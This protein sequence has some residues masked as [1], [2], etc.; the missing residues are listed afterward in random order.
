MAAAFSSTSTSSFPSCSFS[1]PS[2]PSLSFP[3][4]F[5]AFP[6]DIVLPSSCNF[7]CNCNKLRRGSLVQVGAKKKK[8]GRSKKGRP[9]DNPNDAIF[10]PEA[11]LL[12]K[13]VVREDGKVL[14]EFA[15]A[16]EEK[17]YQALSLQLESSLNL[18]RMRHYE[19]VFL[20]HGKHDAET[21]EIVTK[22]EDFIREKKGRIYRL[23]DWGLRML[24]YEIKKALEAHYILMNFEMDSKFLNDFKTLLDKD[25]RVIR[26]LVTKTKQAETQ[27]ARP[28]MEYQTYLAKQGLLDDDGFWDGDG[29]GNDDDDDTSGDTTMNKDEVGNDDDDDDGGDDADGEVIYVDGDEDSD[30]IRDVTRKVEN[31]SR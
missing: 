19:V 31:V 7:D 18:E 12:K 27:Y 6:T 11:V 22:V 29:Y 1:F 20:I 9:E 13:K 4:N 5:I 25:E 16:E 15:D 26:H 8:S 30:E 14:P 21:E 28:P 23:N 17:L 2:S 3:S 10:F 24:A